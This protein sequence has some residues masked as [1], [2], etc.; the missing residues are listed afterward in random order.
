M[1]ADGLTV[2]FPCCRC[3]WKYQSSKPPVREEISRQSLAEG[4]SLQP[5][6]YAAL[7][8]RHYVRFHGL[9]SPEAISPNLETICQF[10]PL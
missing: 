4:I 3:H 5:D 9:R 7:L 1:I 6:V 10:V 8:V 2:G